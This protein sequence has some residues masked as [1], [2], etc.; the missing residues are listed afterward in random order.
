MAAKGTKTLLTSQPSYMESC[1][2]VSIFPMQHA[3]GVGAS[4]LQ[5]G[6]A[7]EYDHDVFAKRAR[8]LFL[9]FA[10]AFAGRNHQYDGNNAPGDSEHGQKGTELM[11]PQ[12]S[13]HV[14]NK[15]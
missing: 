9:A 5:A 14:E 1:F 8:L 4:C 10:E 13:K 2:F 6:A 7:V 3:S 12:G 11:G 15:V